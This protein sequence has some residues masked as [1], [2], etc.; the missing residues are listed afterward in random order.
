MEQLV[1]DRSWQFAFTTMANLALWAGLDDE[2]SA[3][4]E[5]GITLLVPPNRR[6]NRAEIDVPN[7][8]TVAMRN[9]ARDLVLCHMIKDNYHEAGVFA[10]SEVESTNQFL[11]VSEL[12]TNMWITTTDDRLRFQSVGVVLADQVAK[13][14]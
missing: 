12:G 9:Y 3:V 5:H 10:M 4:Y 8:L 13:N 7:L 14:G 6:F 11:V 2:I 1:Y